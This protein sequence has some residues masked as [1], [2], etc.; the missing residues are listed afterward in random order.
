VF[1]GY[2]F[3]STILITT[4]G[5]I[6][7]FFMFFYIGE[8]KWIRYYFGKI[9]DFV[10]HLF[11]VD[12]AQKQKKKFNRMNRLIVTVKGKYGLIGLSLL[13]PVLFS[14]P[15][16]SLLAARYYDKKKA[17]IPYMIVSIVIWSF[18]LTLFYRFF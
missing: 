5:G 12:R 6:A 3:T 14:I 4:L 18:T 11:G 2:S 17:T 10:F 1:A 16:G 9:M 15:L 13:T 8:I 7:G